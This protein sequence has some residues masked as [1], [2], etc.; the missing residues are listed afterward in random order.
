MFEHICGLWYKRWRWALVVRCTGE[1]SGIWCMVG[2]VPDRVVLLSMTP[3]VLSR[4]PLVLR[5]VPRVSGCVQCALGPSRCTRNYE[6][7][8]C[9]RAALHDKVLYYSVRDFRQN[10]GA[11]LMNILYVDTRRGGRSPKVKPLTCR[12]SVDTCWHAWHSLVG[13]E[14]LVKQTFVLCLF[15]VGPEVG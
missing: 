9:M 10:V 14:V 6:K 11:L 1:F 12:S 7:H 4:G 5:R 2:S 15:S 3:M 13:V 8:Y